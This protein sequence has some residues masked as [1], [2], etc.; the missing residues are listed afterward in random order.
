MRSEFWGTRDIA[1]RLPVGIVVQD[2]AGRI[3]QSNAAAERI[4]GVGK[5]QLTVLTSTS[6]EWQAIRL[7]GSPYPGEEHPSQLTAR[8]G[9]PIRDAIMGLRRPDGDHIWISISFQPAP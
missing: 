7:D 2:R 4:L 3:I 1:D 6:P 5:E 8:T 9:V